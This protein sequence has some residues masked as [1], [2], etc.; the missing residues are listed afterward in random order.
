MSMAADVFVE[1]DISPDC[2]PTKACLPNQV[3]WHG[4]C[5]C[6]DGYVRYNH[7]CFKVRSHGEDCF[8]VEQCPDHRMQCKREPGSSLDVKYCL[9]DKYHPWN[10]TMKECVPAVN[11]KIML[12][13]L[14][15]KVNIE[16]LFRREADDIFWTLGIAA[17]TVL[18][19]GGTLAVFCV[20][21]GCYLTD[22]LVIIV[23]PV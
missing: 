5:H 10:K 19:L 15:E 4:Y 11:I 7:T 8:Y 9:C 14:W 23:G 12:S 6:E 16:S 3:C 18:I 17:F 2:S 21:Y 13:E 1:L 22:W 20:V